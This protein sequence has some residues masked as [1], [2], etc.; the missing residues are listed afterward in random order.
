MAKDGENLAEKLDRLYDAATTDEQRELILEIA[1]W[2]R[3]WVGS[4]P[5][6]NKVKT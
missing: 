5:M 4:V 2:G 1:E 3:S 6:K